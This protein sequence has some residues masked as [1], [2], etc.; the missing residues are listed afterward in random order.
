MQ[1]PDFWYDQKSSLLSVLL[2][3]VGWFYG[4]TG[5]IRQDR[6][7]PWQAP[8]PVICVGNLVAGGQGKTPMALSLG[9][10][11][12]TKGQNIHFLSRGY[13]GSLSGPLQV[14]PAR[15]TAAEVGDEPLL[16]ADIAPAWICGDRRAG[17]EAALNAGA[18][19]MVMDDGFQNLA[20]K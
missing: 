13:G 16:L 6:A 5:A 18:E 8:I 1:P 9:A 17:I 7:R 12:K 20:V 2:A 10:A 11:L 15:H 14:D 3:P 4:L 19:I